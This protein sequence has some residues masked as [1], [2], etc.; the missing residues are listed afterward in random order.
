MSTVRHL[1]A[2]ALV[3]AAFCST[4][5]AGAQQLTER[6]VARLSAADHF[7]SNGE[8]LTAP[9]AIL[10]QDRANYHRFGVRDPEDTGDR[11]FAD[12]GNR[13]RLESMLDRAEASP[14]AYDAIVNGTPVVEVL[15]YRLSN[16]NHAVRVRVP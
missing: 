6:Y 13:A 7:N 11:F 15:I 4:A 5:P 3:L 12:A 8:R 16:G 1:R 10:R 2:A 14:G 9:A